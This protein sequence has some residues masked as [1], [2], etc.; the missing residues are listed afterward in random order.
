MIDRIQ[1]VPPGLSGEHPRT[2]LMRRINPTQTPVAGPTSSM[3]AL[4][5]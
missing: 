4:R 1:H 5:P 3:L 2:C